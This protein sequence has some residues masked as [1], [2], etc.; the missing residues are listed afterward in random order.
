MSFGQLAAKIITLALPVF[1]LCTAVV[2]PN[3]TLPVF[4]AAAI[5]LFTS[6]MLLFFLPLSLAFQM[7]T[8][9]IPP[10]P[11]RLGL[12][13]RRLRFQLRLPT[14]RFLLSRRLQRCLEL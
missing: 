8:C 14:G 2:V 6:I 12:T 1:A 13:A 4:T 11:C 3:A 10:S 7:L 9:T 5:A